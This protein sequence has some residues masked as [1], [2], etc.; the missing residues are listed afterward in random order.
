MFQACQPVIHPAVKKLVGKRA[1]GNAECAQTEH[2]T[3][4]LENSNET[5][6]KSIEV[7]VPR[8]IPPQLPERVLAAPVRGEHCYQ[9]KK[10]IVGNVSKWIPVCDRDDSAS[11][12]WM[13][14]FFFP[15]VE[16]FCSSVLTITGFLHHYYCVMCGHFLILPEETLFMCKTWLFITCSFWAF[17]LT[18]T[19]CV[20]MNQ[21]KYSCYIF[22]LNFA[23]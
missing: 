5:L 4:C 8:Y 2:P 22:F 17:S 15:I 13:V 18:K 12:K 14:S 3:V 11:H 7:K 6:T 9:K 23:F 1:V 10:I 19:F 16:I 21:S 20:R